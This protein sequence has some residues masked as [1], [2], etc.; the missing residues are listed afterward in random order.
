MGT[1]TGLVCVYGESPDLLAVTIVLYMDG[2]KETA[3]SVEGWDHPGFSLG[4]DEW[5]TKD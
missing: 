1:L 4:M 3:T 5:L 2:N